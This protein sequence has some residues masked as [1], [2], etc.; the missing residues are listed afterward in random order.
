[1]QWGP[2]IQHFVEAILIG[3]WVPNED[4]WPGLDKGAVEL[5]PFSPAVDAETRNWVST[6]YEQLKS[7]EF[8][9]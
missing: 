4:Y 2:I 5:A 7:G 3:S 9:V 6:V 8:Q 1:M